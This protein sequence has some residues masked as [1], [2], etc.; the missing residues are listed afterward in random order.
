MGANGKTTTS[1]MIKSMYETMG[2]KTGLLGT[3]A[4][5]IHSDHELEAHST[6]PDVVYVQKLMVKMVHNGTKT[7]VME[8]SS[9]ALVLGRCD[10]VDLD[11]AVFTNLTRDH[12]DFTRQRKIIER[13]RGGCLLRWWILN[14]IAQ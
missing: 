9:H 6:T 12:M 1:Y 5:Y 11:I 14:G 7:C 10:K 4:Y 2:L 8:A 3:I 13:P